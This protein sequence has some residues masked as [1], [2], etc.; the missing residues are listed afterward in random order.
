MYFSPWPGRFAPVLP[1]KGRLAHHV[2]SLGPSR[3]HNNLILIYTLPWANS[4][5]DFTVGLVL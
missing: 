5:D 2:A 3:N 1:Y 4:A